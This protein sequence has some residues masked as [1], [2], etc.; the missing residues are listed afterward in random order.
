MKGAVRYTITEDDLEER[1]P[2][3]KAI[4]AELRSNEQLMRRL[5]EYA[6]EEGGNLADIERYL[7]ANAKT[8]WHERNPRG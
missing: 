7:Q 8:I 4:I 2:G 5:E 6:L 1:R 3:I